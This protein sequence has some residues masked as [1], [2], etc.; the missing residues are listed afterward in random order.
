MRQRDWSNSDLARHAGVVPSTVSMILSEQKSPGLEFCLGVAKAFNL[1]PELVMRYAGLLPHKP[2]NDETR[3]QI[4][5]YYDQ[6]PPGDKERL[7]VLARAL[8]EAQ[9]EYKTEIN[10]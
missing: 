7:R 9:T 2:E 5:H 1:P 4:L 8:A 6:M 3:E 10:R